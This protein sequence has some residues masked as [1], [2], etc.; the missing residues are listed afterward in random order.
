MTKRA[1]RPFSHRAFAC[2]CAAVSLHDAFGDRKAETGA[3][4]AIR[5][6]RFGLCALDEFFE[7]TRQSFRWDAGS[8]VRNAQHNGIRRDAGIDLNVRLGG[9]M[10]DGVGHNIPDG[11]LGQGGI[12]PYQRKIVRQIDL[13]LL[14]RAVSPRITG[15]TFGHFPQI[16]PVAPQFQAR[17]ASMRVIARRFRTISSR[18]S[19]SFLIWP[20]RSFF[21]AWSSLS[22]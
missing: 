21:A 22:P 18:S 11:L 16:N 1:P 14:A 5:R 12:G 6:E 4:I 15:H 13:D 20:S 19:A 9:S 8:I 17:P 7:D 3:L 2:D 10:H